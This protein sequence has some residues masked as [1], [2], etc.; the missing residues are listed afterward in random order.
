MTPS[1]QPRRIR[2]ADDRPPAV[3][4]LGDMALGAS[5]KVDITALGPATVETVLWQ[6]GGRLHVTVVAKATFAFA[7]DAAMTRI[8]P[9]EILRAEIHHNKNPMRSVRATGDLAP[10]QPHADVVLTGH[11][12][13]PAGTTVQTL[14][15]RLVVFREG[16]LIDKTLYV[17]GDPNGAETVP[18]DR[19]PL[20]YERAF[21]GIGWE[22]NPLG[23]GAGAATSAKSPNVIDPAEPK[24][25]AG[26]GPISRGWPLRKRLLGVAD[27]K[28]LDRPIA[29]VPA[30]FDWAYFQS[31]P[32]DQRTEYLAG[33]E[34]IVLDGMNPE[35]AHIQSY[36]PAARGFAR[37][38]GVADGGGGHLLALSA[39]TLRIDADALVCSVTWRGSFPVQGEDALAGLRIVAGVESTDHPL[40]WPASNVTAPRAAPTATIDR[41]TAVLTVAAI[42]PP[43]GASTMM[44]VDEPSETRLPTRSRPVAPVEIVEVSEI[45]E[46]FEDVTDLASSIHT[47]EFVDTPA[48]APKWLGTMAIEPEAERA[49]T[50]APAVPFRRGP[51]AL[52]PPQTPPDEGRERLGS[53][54]FIE[55]DARTELPRSLPFLKPLA[56]PVAARSV[57][58]APAPAPARWEEPPPLEQPTQELKPIRAA[59]KR[60]RVGTIELVNDT[61]LALAAIPWGLTPSRD[62][63]TVIAKAT[64]DLVPGGPAVLRAA[65]DAPEGERFED[66]GGAASC[67]YP[68]DFALYKVRA[69]VVLTGHACAPKGAV[70]TMEA[71]LAFG[72]EGNSFSRGVVVLGD[73]RW[74]AGLAAAR[75]SAPEPFVRMPLIHARAFG[76]KKCDANPVGT[77]F[78]DRMRRGPALLPNL[79][80]PGRRLR[81]PNQTA[82]PACFA[83]IPR[84]WKDLWASRG[85]RRAVWPCF[86]EELDWTL[87]QAAPPAQQLAFLRGDEAF[88]IAGMRRDHPVLTGSLPGI[89]ARAVVVRRGDP[90]EIALRLDT[91]VFDLDAMT[92][93]LI[94]RGA[95]TV[96]DERAPDLD[97]IHLH[98]ESAA[99]E[100]TPINLPRDK[101]LRR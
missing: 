27:R 43:A 12:C 54:V 28:A 85:S 17:R 63:F 13:A 59:R 36:L 55:D 20:M 4:R 19:I 7:L 70:T 25:V 60:P 29:E 49:A 90:E 61:A 92:L 39:D 18:F 97:A 79:E 69:D 89:R 91:V 37:V 10:F 22:D 44:L 100:P 101:A 31:A 24:R 77:G 6:M 72:S 2:L 38:H 21:G 46:V 15:V 99:A 66:F 45:S 8:D 1:S 67:V 51:A 78:P 16:P 9:E 68:T 5:R 80:D 23:V 73:R 82:E 83:P 34:W 41:P 11:A 98:V 40:E 48:A 87:F 53:T 32:I 33:S 64:C 71:H 76:G 86:P 47:E 96:P 30:G 75:P 26:F 62:C 35:Y 14:S 42:L 56:P 58:P 88:E 50:R 74:E 3:I 81:T 95:A 93:Q 57:A 65:A 94:W 52:P 84:S